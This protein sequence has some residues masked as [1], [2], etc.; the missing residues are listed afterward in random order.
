MGQV[1][2]STRALRARISELEDQ[3]KRKNR[4]IAEL[5][6][7]IAEQREPVERFERKVRAYADHLALTVRRQDDAFKLVERLGEKRVIGTYQTL[8]AVERGIGRFS[9]RMLRELKQNG[10]RG[11]GR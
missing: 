9:K 10:S 6:K 11:R 7:K 1:D 2:R 3:L 5:R 4:R 8:A